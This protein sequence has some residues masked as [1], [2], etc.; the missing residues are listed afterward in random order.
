MDF[1]N[2]LY[3]HFCNTLLNILSYNAKLWSIPPCI[4]YISYIDYYNHRYAKNKF[5][6]N[7]IRFWESLKPLEISWNMVPQ[8]ELLWIVHHRENQNCEKTEFQWNNVLVIL[9]F[10][11]LLLYQK[12][13]NMNVGFRVTTFTKKP[14]CCL[15]KLIV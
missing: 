15:F 11:K 5:T 7:S 3:I 4:Y 1:K 2:S 6:V 14:I 9:D 10:A 13:M 12:N 8:S